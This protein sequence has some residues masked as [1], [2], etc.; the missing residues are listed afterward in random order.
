M[1]RGEIYLESLGPTSGHEQQG[2]WPVLIVSPDAFNLVTRRAVVVPITSCGEATR[3]AGFTVSLTGAGTQ[4]TG[5]VRCAQP[6]SLDLVARQTRRLEAVP[7]NPVDDVLARL[8]TL[9]A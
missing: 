7:V 6:R 9:F 5:V 3:N 1:K 2:K 8:A 4:T